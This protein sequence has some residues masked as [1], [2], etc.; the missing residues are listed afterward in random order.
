MNGVNGLHRRRPELVEGFLDHDLP[1]F[2]WGSGPPLVYLRG[3]STTNANPTGMQRSFEV[4]MMRSL[5]Q[6]FHVHAVTRPAHLPADVTMADIATWHADAILDRFD[7]PVDVLG[8]SSGGSVALQLAADHP[9][10][11]HRMVVAASGYTMSTPARIAQMRYVTAIAEGRRGAHYL[12]P[13]KV[14]TRAV[15]LPLGAVMWL[16]DPLLRPKDPSDMVAFA[17][18]EDTFNLEDRL[19]EISA[20]LLVIAGGRDSV[21]PADIVRDTAAHV[22][23]G[24]LLVYASAGH[25]GTITSRTFGRDVAD[26]LS[27]T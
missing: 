19:R 6:Q 23:H 7:G 9:Q 26:F 27:E 14:S 1:Y 2:A 12:A 22:Q 25:G 20:P 18:A 15:A 16:L 17:R 3:F 4:R 5:S 8:V 11:V 10:T 21:Y 13:Q 24:K